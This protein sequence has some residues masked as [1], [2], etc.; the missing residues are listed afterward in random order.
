MGGGGAERQV[1]Y[2]VEGLA[3]QGEEVH[4]GLIMG[5]PNLERLK[6]AGVLIHHLAI[7]PSRYRFISPLTKLMRDIQPDV[8]YLW[9]QPFD[10]FGG[11]AAE[12]CGIPCIHAERTQPELM[13]NGLKMWLRRRLVALSD[14]VIANSDS[15]RGFWQSR[16]SDEAVVVKIPNIVPLES[17]MRVTAARETAGKVLAVGRL[18]M[19]KNVQTLIEAV[20]KLSREGLTV[21]VQVVG[22]GP[23]TDELNNLIVSN[24]LT[25]S[26]TLSGFREDVWELMRGCHLFVSLSLVEGEPNAVLEAEVLG[27]RLLLSDIPQH[28]ASVP[29][30]R[31]IFV[32]PLSVEEV[33]YSLRALMAS[34]SSLE[35]IKPNKHQDCNPRTAA[36]VSAA[37]IKV[38]QEVI[39]RHG[40]RQ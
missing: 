11:I 39:A 38:F 22:T 29:A 7:Y 10:V 23:C 27:C 37:H 25:D 2:L 12:L 20:G 31:A 1:T 14:G 36:A 3:G 30:G 4:V 24:K 13:P 16:V 17:L 26:V 35:Q 9:L 18:D 40:R 19:N 15:G 5:G 32:N 34:T 33:A 28:R 6:R 21:P 8:V